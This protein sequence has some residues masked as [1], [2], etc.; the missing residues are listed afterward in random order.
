MK[1]FLLATSTLL[2]VAGLLIMSVPVKA[3]LDLVSTERRSVN[4]MTILSPIGELKK[5]TA[6]IGDIIRYRISYVNVSS[7]QVNVLILNRLPH[8][9]SNVKVFDQGQYDPQSRAITWKIS[10]LAPAG[11]G[12]V[13]FEAEVE[14]STTIDN[15]AYI[16]T[17]LTGTPEQPDTWFFMPG[18][19]NVSAT[20]TTQLITYAP[21]P[22][23]WVA[24]DSDNQP[25]QSPS[26]DL[27]E[28]TTTGTMVIITVSHIY[29]DETRVEGRLFHRIHIPGY[30]SLDKPGNPG[31]PVVG[32]AIEVPHDVALSMQIVDSETVTLGR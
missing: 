23:G 27:K 29:V 9:L 31:L 2:I 4:T 28:E 1:S 22:S 32:T 6:F 11:L 14:S 25:P 30:Y 19:R 15:V 16:K 8:G 3:Q 18:D 20:N 7:D 5:D 13:E 24:L 12:T 17:Q 26:I 10:R 21:S